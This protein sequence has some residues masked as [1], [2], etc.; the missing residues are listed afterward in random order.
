MQFIEKAL[1]LIVGGGDVLEHLKQLVKEN[2]LEDRVIFK[3]RQPYE[4]LLNLTSLA[5]LGLTLDKDTNI[6]Y[7]YSLPNK[8]FDYIQAGIPV[9]ASPLPEI[10]K[11]IKEYDIGDF[12]PGHEPGM[13]ARKV[14]EIIANQA[15][16]AGWKKNVTF[17]ASKLTWENEEQQLKNVYAGYV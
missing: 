10:E 11:I 15:L 4:Q 17:A 9:L 8:L 6:N 13:I 16:V 3:P 12:I 7:R 1:L 14:N 5:D 2:R